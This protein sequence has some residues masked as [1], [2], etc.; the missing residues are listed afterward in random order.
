MRG[1]DATTSYLQTQQR[2][3]VYA[4]LPSH[5]GFSELSFEEL[6]PFRKKL[7]DMEKEEGIKAVKGFARKMKRERR[8]RPKTVLKL[9]KSVYGI[10]DAGQSFSMFMQG[11]YLKHCKM[12]QRWIH[13]SFIAFLRMI[14]D[15]S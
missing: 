9:N 10:P 14:K 2:V 3:M 11:L 15:V 6:A 4:Y 7:L 5:H 8:E 12:V 1:W 13:A